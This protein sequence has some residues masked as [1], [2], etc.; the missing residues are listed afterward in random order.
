MS[1]PVTRSIEGVEY[2][3][4]AVDPE[5]GMP[6]LI[7]L[8]KMMASALG[9]SFKDVESVDQLQG[10]VAGGDMGSIDIGAALKELAARMD[11]RQ[12]MADIKTLL[13]GRYCSFRGPGSGEGGTLEMKHFAGDYGRLFKVLGLALEVNY[14]RFLSVFKSGLSKV[15]QPG[16]ATEAK[17]KGKASTPAR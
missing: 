8:I 4:A 17:K 13:D 3:V 10:M 15:F 16:P 1:K 14:S 12:V 11:E 7:R 5:E 9:E 2:T 6:V